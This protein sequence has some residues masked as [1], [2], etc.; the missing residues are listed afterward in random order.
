VLRVVFN[1]V[2]LAAGR[3]KR[4]FVATHV[5]MRKAPAVTASIKSEPKL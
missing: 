1:A 2:D 4:P 5:T 3:K